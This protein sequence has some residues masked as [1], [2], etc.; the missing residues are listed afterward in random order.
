[1]IKELIIFNIVLYLILAFV[2]Q[3]IFENKIMMKYMK[4]GEQESQQVT[5]LFLT[6]V[7]LFWIIFL[8][9]IIRNNIN[10]EEE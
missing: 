5:G 10:K 7:C 9:F 2:W 1:M 3:I 4:N 8:P 6:F